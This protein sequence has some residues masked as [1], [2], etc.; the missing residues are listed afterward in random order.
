MSSPRSLDVLLIGCWL[1]TVCSSAF[2]LLSLPQRYCE[3]ATDD[4]RL[5][6]WSVGRFAIVGMALFSVIPLAAWNHNTSMTLVG[7][8]LGICFGGCDAALRSPRLGKRAVFGLPLA[9]VSCG[10]LLG[11]VLGLG[12]CW[13]ST[14]APLESWFRLW[15]LGKPISA[16]YRGGVVRIW[17]PFVV[18][19]FTGVVAGLIGRTWISASVRR[20]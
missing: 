17:G 6:L 9:F 8:L 16:W 4:R 20:G 3:S 14:Q 13:W 15:M 18:A 12:Y 5:L 7:G 10:L 11:W 1:G 2:W 19:L